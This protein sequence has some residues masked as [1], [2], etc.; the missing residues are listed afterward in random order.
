MPSPFA[1]AV[2]GLAIAAALR[3]ERRA[4]AAWWVTAAVLAAAPDLDVIA[5]RFGVP[6]ESTWG[7]RGISHSLFAALLLAAVMVALGFRAGAGRW[8]AFALVLAATASHGLLDAFTDGGLG[9]ALLAPFTGARYFFPWRPIRV[10]PLGLSRFFSAEG[11]R[12]LSSE[13]VWVLLP[14]L[15]AFTASEI[16]R[17]RRRRPAPAL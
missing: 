13:S 10:A 3:P 2:A 7:H 4:P 15:L 8:R 1:H 16:L 12:V 5:F 11:L 6:Y 17:R 14:S 9:P